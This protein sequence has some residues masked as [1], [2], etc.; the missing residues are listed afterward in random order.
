MQSSTQLKSVIYL[1]TQSNCNYITLSVQSSSRQPSL[2]SRQSLNFA[3]N[4]DIY[5]EFNLPHEENRKIR[6]LTG[7]VVY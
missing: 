7:L 1:V 3:Q 4:F 6:L 5:E 2:N